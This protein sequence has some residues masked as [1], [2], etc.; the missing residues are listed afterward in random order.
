[1]SAQHQS[2]FFNLGLYIPNT[3]D[4]LADLAK[5]PSLWDENLLRTTYAETSHRQVQDI[6]LRFN[7]LTDCFDD[8]GKVRDA[9]FN[10]LKVIDYRALKLLPSVKPVLR[11]LQ[12]L[13]QGKSVG[14]VLIT[15]LKPGKFIT[16]H[17]DEGDSGLYYDRFHIP[18]QAGG[19]FIA[20]DEAVRM[21]VGEVWWFNNQ[22][23]HS[24]IN[25]GEQ[26]R[27]HLI[28]D[29]RLDIAHPLYKFKDHKK[30]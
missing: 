2:N 13:L 4:I 17:R 10:S 5:N 1:M 22:A 24:V 8:E 19:L 27:I 14:K 3:K 30:G 6:W 9:I 11:T 26:E 7:D 12:F 25:T 15:K 28:V 23:V 18:L 21:G 20:G 16:P 29:I